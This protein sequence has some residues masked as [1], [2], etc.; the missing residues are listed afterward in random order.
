M[1]NG[2]NT[3]ATITPP[4][5]T[6]SKSASTN[7]SKGLATGKGTDATIKQKLKLDSRLEPIHER[8]E[9]QPPAIQYTPVDTAVAILLATHKLRERQAGW[10]HQYDEECHFLPSLL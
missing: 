10:T 6:G 5:R 4:N 7:N 3:Y 9:S 8:I 1:T 2:N